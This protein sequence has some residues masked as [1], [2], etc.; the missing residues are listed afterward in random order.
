MSGAGGALG[1]VAK[2]ILCAASCDV[3][4]VVLAVFLG[5]RVPRRKLQS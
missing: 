2:F 1:H 5:L 3:L 4:L